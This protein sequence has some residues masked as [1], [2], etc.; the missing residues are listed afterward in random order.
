[1]KMKISTEARRRLKQLC[2]DPEPGKWEWDQTTWRW[3]LSV[4]DSQDAPDVDSGYIAIAPLLENRKQLEHGTLPEPGHDKW[5]FLFVVPGFPQDFLLFRGPIQEAKRVL[6]G[7]LGANTPDLCELPKPG[8]VMS[9]AERAEELKTA[10]QIF[11]HEDLINPEGKKRRLSAEEWKTL[12]RKYQPLDAAI[13]EEARAAQ[14]EAQIDQDIDAL[15][16]EGLLEEV[17]DAQG[18]P[19]YHDG[20]PVLRLTAKGE[21]WKNHPELRRF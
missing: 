6:D 5:G 16:A 14:I 17:T 7:L 19:L 18:R 21:L 8:E 3:E 9:E 12:G 4:H 15:I 11:K 2:A 20:E 13:K 1:M 10:A